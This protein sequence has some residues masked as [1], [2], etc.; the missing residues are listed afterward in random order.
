MG[1]KKKITIF[2]GNYLMLVRIHFYST[3]MRQETIFASLGTWW[4]NPQWILSF[5]VLKMA[6]Y[7]AINEPMYKTEQNWIEQ[8]RNYE[9]LDISGIYQRKATNLSI[10]CKELYVVALSEREMKTWRCWNDRVGG[11]RWPQPIPLTSLYLDQ[12]TN[13]P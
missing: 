7:Q 9:L 4:E 11:K 6:G 2:L 8:S 13:L 12:R 3:Q 1:G 10:D 5:H